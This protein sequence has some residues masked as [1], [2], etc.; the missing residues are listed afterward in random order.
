MAKNDRAFCDE[1]ISCLRQTYE[2]RISELNADKGYICTRRKGSK[3]NLRKGLEQIF[4]RE[5]ARGD[6][7][8]LQQDNYTSK[9]GSII[10]IYSKTRG[11]KGHFWYLVGRR[12]WGAWVR[13][14]FVCRINGSET[15]KCYCPVI[16]GVFSEKK[17]SDISSLPCAIDVHGSEKKL[18]R[19]VLNGCAKFSDSGRN[20]WGQS[21]INK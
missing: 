4:L 6:G 20:N 11:Q 5:V 10:H 7:E 9:D 18:L 19:M 14:D 21:K 8:W 3:V 15:Y 12:W 17:N 2:L 1:N 16:D 13:S